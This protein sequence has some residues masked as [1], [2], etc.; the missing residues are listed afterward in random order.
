MLDGWA[1]WEIKDTFWATSKDS[2]LWVRNDPAEGLDGT[3]MARV[4][5]RM[6]RLVVDVLWDT[7][8]FISIP[9]SRQVVEVAE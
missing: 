4:D 5:A 6:L 1:Q 7:M 8:L 3:M 9:C 2:A